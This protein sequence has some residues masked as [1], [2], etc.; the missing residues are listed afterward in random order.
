MRVHVKKGFLEE[1]NLTSVRSSTDSTEIQRI[2]RNHYEQLHA[3]KM[4]TTEETNKFLETHTLLRLNWEEI[5]YINKLPAMKL[6]Q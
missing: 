3:S 1:E 2:T 5:K 6:N 4:Y